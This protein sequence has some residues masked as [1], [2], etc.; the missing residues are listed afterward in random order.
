M[1]RQFLLLVFLTLLSMSEVLA[2]TFY[3]QGTVRGKSDNLTIPGVSVFIKGTTVGTITDF[4]GNFKIKVP[5]KESVIVFS[6]VGM[7]TQEFVVGDQVRIDALMAEDAINMDEVVVVGY[8]TV[9][10]S[11]ATG[12]ISSVKSEDL[13]K[14]PVASVAQALQGKATGVQVISTSGRAG[15]ETQISLRGNGSLSAGNSVLY[16]IDGVSQSSMGNISPQDIESME[17]LKDA[18]STAIYGSRAA[19]GV[20]LIT[21]KNG[22]A[23]KSSV[24][25]NAY[26]GI[27]DLVKK[28]ELLNAQ[29]YVDV[30]N[31]SI[32]NELGEGATGL[33][34]APKYDTDWIGLV[35]REHAKVQNYQTS[36]SSGNEKTQFYWSGS[37][38]DQEG[39]IK[40]DQYTKYR[41]KLNLTH[42]V[43]DW[44][45][46]GVNSFFAASESVPL[47][48]DNSIYQPWSGAMRAQPNQPAFDENGKPI[49]YAGFTNP[50]FAFER[51]LTSKNTDLGGAFFA[52]I[53]PIEGLVWHSSVSGNI[54]MNR[55]NRYDSPSSK[56]GSSVNGSGYYSTTYNRDFLV[57]NTL[58]YKNSLLDK[59]LTYTVLIGHS[60]QKWQFEDSY[61][62][63]QNFPSESLRWLTSAGEITNG[64]SY[65]SA[66]ALES[67]FSRFQFSYEGRYNMMLSLRRDA[68]SK[69]RKENNSG[70]FP[71]VSLGWNA[72]KESF[73]PQD[74]LVSTLSLRAS[75]GVTGNQSGI[76]YA[77]GQN[78]LVSGKN[79]NDKPGIAATSVYN[80]DLTWEKSRSLNAGLNLGLFEDRLTFTADGYI[81]KS[82]DLLNNV[83]ITYESGF[84][85]KKANVGQTQ[86]IGFE[87]GLVGDI[88]KQSDL[89]VSL[90]ANFS[91]NK[92]EVV[93]AGKK[94]KDYYTTSFVSIVKEGYA[95]GSFDLLEYQG[96]ADEDYVYIDKDGNEG[97]TV[98]AGNALYTDVNGDGQITSADSKVYEG[99]I[100]PIFGG[101]GLNVDYKNF[102]FHITAQY[103]LGK[104]TYNMSRKAQVAGAP[105]G[106]KKGYSRNMWTAQ[107][108]YWTPE[109]HSDI[110][111][112]TTDSDLSAWNNKDSSRFLEDADYLRISDI[113]LG[114][115]FGSKVNFIKTARIYLQARNLFTLTNYSGLDPEVQYVDPSATN[116]KVSAG[117]DNGGIPN[118]R[119]FLIGLN[120]NF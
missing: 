14:A 35:T 21:T 56:Q 26:Y 43:A 90:N 116:N 74:I 100:A 114:Y 68:S 96:V 46:L 108:D 84:R 10:K 34:G 57:E 19:N 70:V 42:R 25:V 73:F 37:Y 41:T 115:S 64:R 52:D 86:N 92:S 39:V 88:I 1:K 93:D 30:Q 16:I 62:Q 94:S 99:G 24:N 32:I 15:D 58:T 38:Y 66:N 107:L 18:A 101:L 63:G 47:S 7:K 2:Q 110:P 55:Y 60:F 95:I 11:E 98:L 67:Y 44:L 3:V 33:L 106:Q 51:Q 120:L 79:Y 112:L 20:I 45:K 119:T 31:Q 48:E 109:N 13:A 102:D 75:Y 36:F 40:K 59:S 104:K 85:T 76:S 81:K 118:S 87:L 49:A 111:Q 5:S 89:N 103:S 65:Y 117:V 54:H 23:G 29:Q 53:T 78:L 12:A 82:D 61:V 17:I 72:S 50:M 28:P 91:Y 4:D 22:K 80:P 77:S 71:A 83:S 8:G 113:T 97:K 9:K 6:Y 69:F 105:I 27:Q